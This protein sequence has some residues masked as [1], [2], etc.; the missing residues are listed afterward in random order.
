MK[1]PK[2]CGGTLY[3][4]DTGNSIKA[5]VH[6]PLGWEMLPGAYFPQDGYLCDKCGYIEI[7]ARDPKT[8]I[9]N[10]SRFFRNTQEEELNKARLKQALRKLGSNSK[11]KK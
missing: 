3:Q 1:C 2:G 11:A 10:N 6:T 9:Q 5:H 4:F 7:R 8:V